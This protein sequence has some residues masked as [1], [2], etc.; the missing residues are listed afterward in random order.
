MGFEERGAHACY[1][2]QGGQ[3]VAELKS[4]NGALE[5]V[6]EEAEA[7]PLLIGALGA[8]AYSLNIRI[9]KNWR[10]DN[11]KRF[12]KLLMSYGCSRNDAC[13]LATIVQNPAGAMSYQESLF[14]LMSVFAEHSNRKDVMT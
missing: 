12:I 10:C 11:K 14:T 2:M 5:I 13:E 9:P 8:L 6:L 3:P 1:L 7:E 4:I